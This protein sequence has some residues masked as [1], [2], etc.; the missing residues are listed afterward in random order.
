[1]KVHILDK[2]QL[3]G[4]MAEYLFLFTEGD[5][6]DTS[7]KL[8][9]F[10]AGAGGYELKH[11]LIHHTKKLGG[12]GV[13]AYIDNDEAKIGRQLS[14]LEIMPRQIIKEN[15]DDYYIIIAARLNNMHW[16]KKQLL[17][18]N[19]N[20]AN[21]AFYFP[22]ITMDFELFGNKDFVAAVTDAISDAFKPTPLID[23]KLPLLNDSIS[24]IHYNKSLCE[25]I[26]IDFSNRKNLRMLDIGPGKGI[27]SIIFKR[28]LDVNITWIDVLEEAEYFNDKQHVNEN[29]RYLQENYN[30]HIVKGNI[31]TISYDFEV[32]FDIILFSF[33]LEHLHYHPV[34][35]M[36]KILSWLKPSG[37]LY[38]TVPD[39]KRRKGERFYDHWREMPIY[40]ASAP[41]K[42]TDYGH[43]QE[44]H[45]E[46]AIELFD[47]LQLEVE[48]YE[49]DGPTMAFT[50]TRKPR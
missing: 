43:Q 32:G 2:K 50:L 45:Y 44:Y 47:E 25:W 41:L 33:V 29:L 39:N 5:N 6:I 9:I 46:E 49:L 40:D 24:T 12:K 3:L 22:I 21:I 28:L 4:P 14:G 18:Y 37:K 8:V 20:A 27:Q 1:M 16:I 15:P 38:L 13:Y 23:I 34:E 30:F 19:V 7:K 36:K 10:G 26:L 31:E 42:I 35:T 17:N 11:P 48:R